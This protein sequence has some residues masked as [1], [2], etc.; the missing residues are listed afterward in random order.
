VK[1]V[2][3]SGPISRGDL[4]DNVN[5]ATKAF[6]ALAKAG[7]APFCPQLS[8]YCK[9]CATHPYDSAAVLCTGTVEGAPGMT[10]E[11]WMTV[12]LPWVQVSDAVLRLPGDS[13]GA[14]REVE[15]ARSCGIPVYSSVLEVLDALAVTEV[16]D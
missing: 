2:F 11:D 1:R 3:I 16:S 8:V 10:F 5:R 9:P 13:T 12:D 15:F 6:V 14:D 4:A 7:L